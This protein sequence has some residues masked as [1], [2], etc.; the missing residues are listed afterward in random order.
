MGINYGNMDSYDL[1]QNEAFIPI[2][3]APKLDENKNNEL[4]N[5]SAHS[6]R[7]T[8]CSSESDSPTRKSTLDDEENDKKLKNT[9]VDKFTKIFRKMK[10]TPIFDV[11]DDTEVLDENEYYINF[12]NKENIRKKYY[13]NLIYKNIWIREKKKSANNLFI[14]DWDDTIFPT[15]FLTQEEIINDDYL[16]EEYKE[17]FSI[18]ESA[19]LKV[20][21]LAINK[22]DVYIITNSGIGWVEFSSNKYFPNFNKILDKI[23]IISARNE[24]E[25]SYPGEYKIWKDKAFLSLKEKINLYLPTNIICFGDSIDDL[26]AGKNLASKINNSFIKTIKFKEK[27]DLEDMIKEL[28]LISNKFDYFYSSVKNTSLRLDIKNSSN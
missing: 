28:N 26:E 12:K 18:L 13:S 16:P 24:Y 7:K 14:F 15:F 4:N 3:F 1:Y 21:T 8:S 11:K 2:Y 25:D 22:G 19:I 23:H 10:N 5:N 9:K 6:K 17:I 20:L 27:P